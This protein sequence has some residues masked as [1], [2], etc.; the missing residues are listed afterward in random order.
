MPS[1]ATT[2]KKA[3]EK[4]PLPPPLPPERRT[5]GQLVAETVRLYERTFPWSLALGVGPGALTVVA[6]EVGFSPFLAVVGVAWAVVVGA[7][8]VG[9]AFLAAEAPPPREAVGPAL[10][11]GVLVALPASVLT[12]LGILPGVLWLALFGLAVPVAVL[13]RRQAASALARG[14]ALARIDLVHSIGSVATLFLV[15]YLTQILLFVLLN[16]ASDQA[17]AISGFLASLVMS[18]LLFLGTALLYYDQ[19]AR[20]EVKSGGRR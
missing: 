12:G 17:T 10:I 15:T 7:S 20:A 1:V 13:E 14:F 3:R 8:Y 19:A 5:I 16:S 2:R 9:A 11:V 4:K 6:Y 18:P